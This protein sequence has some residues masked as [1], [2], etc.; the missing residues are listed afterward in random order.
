M[1]TEQAP[2]FSLLSLSAEYP[3]SVLRFTDRGADRH[4]RECEIGVCSGILNLWTG[5]ACGLTR[6]SCGSLA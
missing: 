5:G 4:T 1:W 6:P 2:G 3:A